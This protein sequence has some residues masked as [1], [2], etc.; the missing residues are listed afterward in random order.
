MKWSDAV[1]IRKDYKVCS[2][3]SD[4]RSNPKIIKSNK[5]GVGYTTR[6]LHLA[7]AK[8]SGHEACPKRTAGCTTACLHTAGNVQYLNVKQ[9]GRIAKTKLWFEQ[10]EAFKALLIKEIENQVKWSKSKGLKTAI[11]LNGTSDIVW[12]RE[13]PELFTLFP[14][15][16]FYDYTKIAARFNPKWNLPKNY[17]LTFSRA[18]TK[19]NQL[20]CDKVLNWGGNVAIVFSGYGYGRHHKPFPDSYMGRRLVNGD[21]NDLRFFDGDNVFVGLRAK[22]RA[23]KNDHKGFIVSL[24]VLKN[25]A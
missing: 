25:V 21:E 14:D 9:K 2:L 19:S 4:R 13:F 12:E 15:I 5:A 16:Q 23:Y 3:L 11:R 10:P 6:I 8:L 1:K 24:P 20:E 17:Y 22:G 7:P 18:E